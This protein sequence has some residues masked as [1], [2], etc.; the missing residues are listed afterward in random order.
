[1]KIGISSTGDSHHVD[2][3][4]KTRQS[5]RYAENPRDMAVSRGGGDPRGPIFEKKKKPL[6]DVV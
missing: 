6:L 3:E 1:M 4:N 5:R 2:F